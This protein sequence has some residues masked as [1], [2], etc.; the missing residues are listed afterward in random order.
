MREYTGH[1]EPDGDWQDRRDGHLFVRKLAVEEMANN[2]YVI[3]CTVTGD[4]LL[5][6]VAAR[7]DRLRHALEGFE[8]VAAVQT[9][10]HWD[11]VRAWDGIRDDGGIEVWGH[12]GDAALF[13][14]AVDRELSDGERLPVGDL[15]VEVIH[16]PGHTEG[17]LLYLVQGDE[18]PHLFSGDTLFP[19][20]PGNTFGSADNHRRIMDGLE[21]KIFGRLPDGTWVYP[22]HGDD[23]TLGAERPHL[24]EWRERGW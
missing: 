4:A 8:P 5:V 18:R 12:A 7:P 19:G 24:R 9:H 2:V 23:T 22:G 10:G 1:V 14:R 11:H 3:G 17:S 20:G 16:V 15:E 6:D 21:A 13:P